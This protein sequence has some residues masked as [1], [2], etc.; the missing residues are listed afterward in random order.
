MSANSK[1]TFSARN[2]NFSKPNG[3]SQK[4]ELKGNDGPVKINDKIESSTTE[5]AQLSTNHI[6]HIKET[7]GTH[8]TEDLDQLLRLETAKG[9]SDVEGWFSN[10]STVCLQLIV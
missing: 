5:F 3:L 10:Y 8:I 1:Q 7:E 6:I 2:V 4:T 9:K